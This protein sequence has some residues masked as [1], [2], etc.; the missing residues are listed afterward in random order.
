MRSYLRE[1]VN[2]AAA[3]DVN[4]GYYDAARKSGAA[5]ALTVCFAT[6]QGILTAVG[7]VHQLLWVN[8]GPVRPSSL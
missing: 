3:A 6:V 5:D 8:H 1:V 2:Q 7:Q 4:A